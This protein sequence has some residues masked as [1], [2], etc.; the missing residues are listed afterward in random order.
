MS[1]YSNFI[2]EY[3]NFETLEYPDVA[4]ACYKIAGE[5]FYIKNIFIEPPHRSKQ[6]SYKIQEDLTKIAKEA[7]CTYLLG[8]VCPYSKTASFSMLGLLK[9]GFKFHR[10][11]ADMMYFVKRFEENK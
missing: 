1:L 9:D 10:Y 3:D 11:D 6:L 7:G 5:E 8:T 4:F 2:K